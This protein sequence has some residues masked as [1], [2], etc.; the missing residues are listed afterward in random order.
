MP[1]LHPNPTRVLI[2]EDN[3]DL[4]FGLRRTLEA[5]GYLVR[6]ANNGDDALVAVREAA[7][8]LIILDLMMPGPDGFSVLE[9]LRRGGH[10]MPVLILSAR[11]DETDK[12]RGFR[13]GA[14]DFVTKPF[15]VRELVARVAA[16]LR[17]APAGTAAVE[18]ITFGAVEIDVTARRVTRDMTPV[19]LTPLELQLLLTL[20]Q[21]PGVAFS[22]QTLLRDVWG[23]APD[24]RTRTVDLH[25]AELR[26]KLEALPAEP[27][28][29]V[30]VFK[31]GYRFDL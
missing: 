14:D 30:T 19:A 4:A 12:L 3:D 5:E 6:V 17:R 8:Q 21:H 27:R 15:G 25:V 28:H 9:R 7:P 24:V 22:R 29:I 26:R 18:R 13:S 10:A 20:V 11:S 2:V 16:L 23:H 1:G 31:T